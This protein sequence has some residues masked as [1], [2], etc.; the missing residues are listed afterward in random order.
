MMSFLSYFFVG[1]FLSI[2]TQ[3]CLFIAQILYTVCFIPQ[4]MVNFKNK[5]GKGLSEFLLIAYLNTYW[6]LLFYMF[7]LNLPLIYRIMTPV[8]TVLTYGLIFQRL[9]YDSSPEVRWWKFFYAVNTGIFLFFIPAACKDPQTIGALFGW[10]GLAAVLVNQLP[11]IVKLHRDKRVFDL[12]FA[13]IFLT[14]LA[15][16]FESTGSILGQLPLQTILMAT[17]GVVMCSILAV[18]Y[19]MYKR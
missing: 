9:Y 12:S 15:A 8:Q 6:L 19:F 17:R 7:A 1:D 14:G 16:V 13:F 2:V 3:L 18:Q 4:L 11:Q 10:L 5:S